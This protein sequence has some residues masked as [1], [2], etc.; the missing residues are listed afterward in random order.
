MTGFLFGKEEF[1]ADAS[2]SVELLNLFMEYGIVYGGFCEDGDGGVRFF[3]SP[4][5]GAAL[6]AICEKKRIEIQRVRAV[7]LPNLLYKYRK[8]W[9]LA[10]GAVLAAMIMFWSG[11]VLWDIRVTGNERVTYSEVVEILEN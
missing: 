5:S 9:G 8:R 6:I 3:V 10:I 1:R 2:S 7:G 4:L 11:R